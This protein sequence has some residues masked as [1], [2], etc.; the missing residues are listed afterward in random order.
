MP[1]VERRLHAW[2]KEV[3]DNANA[4]SCVWIEDGNKAHKEIVFVGADTEF[5]A[6]KVAQVLNQSAKAAHA[7]VVM[8]LELY[9]SRNGEPVGKGIE[10]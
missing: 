10:F 7:N 9:K 6:K 3:R 2:V 1:K 5:D 8:L 4:L